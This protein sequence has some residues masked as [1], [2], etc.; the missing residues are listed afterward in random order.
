MAS[1]LDVITGR[2]SRLMLKRWSMLADLCTA[3]GCSAPL[4]RDPATGN[5][6]CV[7]HDAKELF[8]D[9]LTQAELEPIDGIT[10]TAEAVPKTDEK[11][12]VET[13]KPTTASSSP[14]DEE[15][16]IRRSRRER[17]EQ[18]DRASQLIAKRLL[19]GWKMIDH[20]CPNSECHS[21]PLVQDRD[22]VQFCVICQQRYMHEADYV[23][24]YGSL[25][26]IQTA[27]ATPREP[28]IPPVPAPGP[29]EA[30]KSTSVKQEETTVSK[31]QQSASSNGVTSPAV[32]EAIDALNAKI[33]ELSS[34]LLVATRPKD[35]IRITKAISSCAKAVHKCQKLELAS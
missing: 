20:P 14:D 29:A 6:K 22:G 30:K 33:A 27:E 17:R 18:G 1:R 9:D 16:M 35:I 8:P 21:V 15:Q 31:N 7:W 34:Q 23:K 25:D 24:K 2:L 12:S 32:Q 28:Q 3:D 4:M 13:E 19:Q 11:L 5:T 10:A 26:Q